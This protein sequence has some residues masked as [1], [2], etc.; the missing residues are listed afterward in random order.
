M[1][2]TPTR[3][4]TNYTKASN[5]ILHST[6]L[7]A[8]QKTAWLQLQSLCIGGRTQAFDSVAEIACEL[9][10]PVR[11]F[12]R[13]VLS[14][15]KLG[16]VERNG[17]D[18]SL[19]LPS[20]T[21]EQ[22]ESKDAKRLSD[23]RKAQLAWN[24]SAPSSYVR[25][26]KPFTEKILQAVR[27]HMEHL[28]VETGV[29]EFIAAVCK[30]AKADDFWAKASAQPAWIFGQGDPTDKKTGHV[31]KLYELSSSKK[32]ANAAWDANNDKDWLEWYASKDLSFDSVERLAVEDLQAA[33]DHELEN[34]QSGEH[35]ATIFI[36]S[37]KA[38]SLIYWTLKSLAQYNV[39]Y[40]PTPN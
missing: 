27:T 8:Q 22:V 12:Q 14:L 13:M 39:Y 36:Y 7:T 10:M 19:L 38:G 28:K 4:T 35:Q 32:A 1:D 33:Q 24:E 17:R 29:G 15:E 34:A 5:E 3:P 21:V 9:R 11:T 37:D 16:L 30:G 26:R 18:I 23:G 20:D 6:V 31:T 40:L 2:L 25:L